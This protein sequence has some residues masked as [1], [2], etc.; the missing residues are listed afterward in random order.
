M[1][2]VDKGVFDLP[3]RELYDLRDDPAEVKNLVDDRPELARDLEYTMDRW[4]DSRL[5]NRPNPLRLEAA[6]GMD[7]VDMIRSALAK[8]GINWD[9]LT[10][11]QQGKS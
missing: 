1:R 11:G 4:I 5:G 8:K 7:G 3:D 6:A 2:T 10:P 9:S